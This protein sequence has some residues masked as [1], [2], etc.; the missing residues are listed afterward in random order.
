MAPETRLGTL[1]AHARAKDDMCGV[2]TVV[3]GRAGWIAGLSVWRRPG[4]GTCSLFGRWLCLDWC[5]NKSRSTPRLCQLRP[6]QWMCDLAIG[7]LKFFD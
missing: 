1:S 6:C 7:L 2:A 5:K 3:V 4:L